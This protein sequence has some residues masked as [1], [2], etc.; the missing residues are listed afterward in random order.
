MRM[1]WNNKEFEVT[2]KIKGIKVN[3]TAKTEEEAFKKAKILL[4]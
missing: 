4:N 1:K 2:L 3:F